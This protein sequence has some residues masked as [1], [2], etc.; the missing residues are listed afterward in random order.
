MDRKIFCVFVVKNNKY[1][2]YIK[3]FRKNKYAQSIVYIKIESLLN[4]ILQEGQNILLKL[5]KIKLY[6]VNFL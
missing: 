5:K 2:T 6:G 1:F 4:R 3:N